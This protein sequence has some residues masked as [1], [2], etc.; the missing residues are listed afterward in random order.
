MARALHVYEPHAAPNCDQCKWTPA[1][2]QLG[3]LST[4]G[5]GDVLERPALRSACLL[6]ATDPRRARYSVS[7]VPAQ[8][9][10][11]RKESPL[12]RGQVTEKQKQGIGELQHVLRRTSSSKLR[13]C[14]SA[15]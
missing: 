13:R 8:R 15:R 11:G 4:F 3:S 10:P 5:Q 2:Q 7:C 14:S 1:V 6:K 12:A 9:Q